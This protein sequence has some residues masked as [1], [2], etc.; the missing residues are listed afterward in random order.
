M[1]AAEGRASSAETYRHEI[2]MIK[3]NRANWILINGVGMALGFWT[4]LHV[5]FALAFGLDFERYGSEAAA[6]EVGIV[7]RR[8]D[9]AANGM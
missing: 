1:A 4:F 6:E 3:R 5:L 2:S 7:R 8:V 9:A